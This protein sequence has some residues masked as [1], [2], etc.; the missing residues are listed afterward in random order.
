[1]KRCQPKVKAFE[2]ALVEAIERRNAGR[3]QLLGE[4]QGRL[5]QR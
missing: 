3:K 4:N 1:M 5:S 2:A